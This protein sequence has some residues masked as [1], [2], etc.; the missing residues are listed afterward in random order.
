[1][2]VK[3][4]WFHD[5]P[6]G[7]RSSSSRVSS[8]S[9]AT[10]WSSVCY[11][12]YSRGS[13]VQSRLPLNGPGSTAASEIRTTTIDTPW[14][15]PVPSHR[16]YAVGADPILLADLAKE[17][18]YTPNGV[19]SEVGPPGDQRA[20]HSAARHGLLRHD[21]DIQRGSPHQHIWRRWHVQIGI[22]H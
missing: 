5:I 6:K 17:A 18:R 15:I 12:P 7:I 20:G 2:S 1:M 22:S 13:P 8:R 16:P 21:A 3:I 19:E 4:S 14:M 10:P 9:F 11:Y